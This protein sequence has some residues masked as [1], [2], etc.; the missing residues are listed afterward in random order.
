MRPDPKVDMLLA[1]TDIGP[2]DGGTMLIPGSHKSNFEHPHAGEL[3][4]VE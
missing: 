1:L 4:R 3:S 2:G